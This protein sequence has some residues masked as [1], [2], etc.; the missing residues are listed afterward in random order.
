MPG[1]VDLLGGLRAS[2]RLEQREREERDRGEDDRG[3]DDHDRGIHDPFLP[4]AVRHEA[5]FVELVVS[6]LEGFGLGAHVVPPD[7]SFLADLG[8]EPHRLAHRHVAHRAMA[9]PQH[10]RDSAVAEV[11]DVVDFCLKSG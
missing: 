5:A 9:V 7:G 10:P 6:D 11:L 1:P 8:D 3:E 4:A 2:L